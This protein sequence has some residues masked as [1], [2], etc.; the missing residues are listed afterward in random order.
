MIA[1][2]LTF[3]VEAGATNGILDP[4]TVPRMLSE[5]PASNHADRWAFQS[6]GRHS[7]SPSERESGNTYL[8][9]RPSLAVALVSSEPFIFD[10][11]TAVTAYGCYQKDNKG[12]RVWGNSIPMTEGQQHALQTYG[13]LT[14]VGVR[15][16]HGGPTGL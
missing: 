12:G 11:R 1:F 15:L 3:E 2:V 16:Q 10:G 13:V 9:P 14:Q 4:E 7:A 6:Q 5:P 8:S